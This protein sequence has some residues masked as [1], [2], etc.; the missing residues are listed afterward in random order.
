MYEIVSSGT[1]WFQAAVQSSL[2]NAHTHPSIHDFQYDRHDT[3]IRT[4]VTFSRVRSSG[5]GETQIHSRSKDCDSRDS[6]SSD[7]SQGKQQQR[8]ESPTVILTWHASKYK[9]HKLHQRYILKRD[10]SP[11]PPHLVARTPSISNTL[12]NTGVYKQKTNQFLIK[13][14]RSA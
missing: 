10:A 11:P 8:P 9:V 1:K 12:G 6:D 13:I 14:G 2:K 3:C 5:Q 7:V 4:N